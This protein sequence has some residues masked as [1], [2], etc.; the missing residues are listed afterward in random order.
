MYMR[1]SFTCS[2]SSFVG[3]RERGAAEGG[4]DEDPDAAPRRAELADGLL[5]PSGADC[6]GL[7]VGGT[8]TPYLYQIVYAH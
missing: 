5:A 6:P 7:G 1:D 2:V 3:L 4:V 8:A